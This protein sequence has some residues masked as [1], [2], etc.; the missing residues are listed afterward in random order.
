MYIFQVIIYGSAIKNM[1]LAQ[2]Q[3]HTSME[4]N[5]RASLKCMKL[6]PPELIFSFVF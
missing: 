2:K 6:E 1:T 4:Q 3:I 5:G